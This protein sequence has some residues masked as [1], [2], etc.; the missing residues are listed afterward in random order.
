MRVLRT[1][2]VILLLLAAA[3]TVAPSQAT[4]APAPTVTGGLPAQ[5]IPP[6]TLRAQAHVYVAFTLAWLL[7]FGYAV[8]LGRRFARVE[9]ELERIETTLPPG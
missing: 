7:V 8:S 1:I 9:R 3:P 2:L 5:P 4:T 6:R